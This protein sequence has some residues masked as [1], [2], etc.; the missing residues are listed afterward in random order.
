HQY[1]DRLGAEYGVT[2]NGSTVIAPVFQTTS[3]VLR[4]YLQHLSWQEVR[5]MDA[6]FDLRLN[7][8]TINRIAEVR[9]WSKEVRRR[10]R[11]ESRFQRGHAVNSCIPLARVRY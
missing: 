4:L 9:V 7:D 1:F 3:P 10:R 5:Q 2:A 8:K 6:A 11:I